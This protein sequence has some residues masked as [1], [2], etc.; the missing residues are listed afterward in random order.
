[1]KTTINILCESFEKS[2]FRNL[3]HKKIKV[4]ATLSKNNT[5]YKINKQAKISF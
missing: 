1:M 3:Q 5:R 2:V 4:N